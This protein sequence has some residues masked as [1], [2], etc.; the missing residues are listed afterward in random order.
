M[1]MNKKGL[2]PT[3]QRAFE[4]FGTLPAEAKVS[5]RVVAAIEGVTP[6]TVWRRASQGLLPKSHKVGGT[7][8]WIV[9][10]LR[11]ARGQQ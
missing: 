3:E 11:A 5:V 4:A 9:G 2:T 7:A 8:R 1:A 6:V 10:E